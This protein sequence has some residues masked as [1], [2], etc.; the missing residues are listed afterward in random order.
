[1]LDAAVLRILGKKQ[2]VSKHHAC[3]S[4]TKLSCTSAVW[5]VHMHVDVRTQDTLRSLQVFG[6]RQ[7][8]D[9]AQDIFPY[10]AQDTRPAARIEAVTHYCGPTS[11]PCRVPAP[12]SYASRPDSLAPNLSVQP[13][14]P[15]PPWLGAINPR[16]RNSEDVGPLRSV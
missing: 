6:H 9:A 15:P 10:Q 4:A 7:Q 11:G 13:P 16:R 2:C 14:P 3:L 1:M 12:G 5:N 8:I